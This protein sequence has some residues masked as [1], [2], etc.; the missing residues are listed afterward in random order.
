MKLL[1]HRLQL[2]KELLQ[3]YDNII[4]QQLDKGIIETVDTSRVSETRKHYLP[5]HPVLTSTKATTKVCIVYDA[6]AKP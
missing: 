3:K 4:K 1:V 5:H 6:S 2:D